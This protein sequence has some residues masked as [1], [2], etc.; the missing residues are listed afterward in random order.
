MTLFR[1]YSARRLGRLI[2]ASG[3]GKPAMFLQCAGGLTMLGITHFLGK[4]VAPPYVIVSL[5]AMLVVS[6]WAMAGYI[7]KGSAA[8][9][10]QITPWLRSP[11]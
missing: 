6:V 8:D 7:S 5:S 4:R 3:A 1:M 10:E 9:H 11:G 2:P